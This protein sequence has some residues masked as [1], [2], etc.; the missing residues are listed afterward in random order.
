MVHIDRARL[1]AWLLLTSAMVLWLLSKLN[2]FAQ[3]RRG[4]D[5][6]LDQYAASGLHV[7]S[8]EQ[9]AAAASLGSCVLC[10]ICDQLAAQEN[11]TQSP[12][13]HLA[14]ATRPGAGPLARWPQSP[15]SP[16]LAQLIADRC[17]T[18]VRL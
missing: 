11:A 1:K 13:D 9:R 5:Q 6:F 16:R 3:G 2:P 10:G 17:P 12:L 8:S 15:P 4:L 18:R 7:I 14:A